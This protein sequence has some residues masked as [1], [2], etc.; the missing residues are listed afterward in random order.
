MSGYRVLGRVKITGY[1]QCTVPDVKAHAV[2]T[3]I[4]CTD[5]GRRWVLESVFAVRDWCPA[6]WWVRYSLRRELKR[7]AK[8]DGE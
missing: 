7:Q 4:A 2:G 3:V 1:H 6:N 5:C 8:N